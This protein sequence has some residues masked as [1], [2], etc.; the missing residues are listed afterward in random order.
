[1]D[2]YSLLFCIPDLSMKMESFY[3]ARGK[4]RLKHIQQYQK[5]GMTEMSRTHCLPQKP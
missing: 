2:F 3:S 1:M 5:K 4:S